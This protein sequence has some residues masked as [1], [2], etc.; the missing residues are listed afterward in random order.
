LQLS[1]GV[2]FQ[3]KNLTDN[4]LCHL[5]QFKKFLLFI[6]SLTE[7]KLFKLGLQSKYRLYIGYIQSEGDIGVF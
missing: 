1:Y 2:G 3:G 5:S 7:V 4:E 6:C